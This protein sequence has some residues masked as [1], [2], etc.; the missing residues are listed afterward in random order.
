MMFQSGPRTGGIKPSRPMTGMDGGGMPV[1]PGGPP[2]PTG[3]DGGGMP[4][5]P[6]GPP[7]PPMTGGI[8][9]S[10]PGMG[11]LPQGGP[12]MDIPAPG[13]PPRPP[14]MPQIQMGGP[15]MDI[16]SPGGPRPGGMPQMGVPGGPQMGPPRSGGMPQ[17]GVPGG[18]FGPGMNLNQFNRGSTPMGGP[19]PMGPMGGPQGSA[20]LQQLQ[21]RFGK[22]AR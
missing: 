19:R 22:Q 18:Q 8:K 9:P 20:L 2:R 14:G 13:G 3:M 21:M 17:M 6:G 15:P 16:P 12:P 5:G 11:G 10:F 4:V 7:R 1:T